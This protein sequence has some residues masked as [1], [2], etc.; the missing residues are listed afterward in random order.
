MPIPP[1]STKGATTLDQPRRFFTTLQAD[2]GLAFRHLLSFT[3]HLL[4]PLRLLHLSGLVHQIYFVQL[5]ILPETFEHWKA[6]GIFGT[7]LLIFKRDC[8]TNQKPTLNP[9]LVTQD[10]SITRPK[11]KLHPV[12]VHN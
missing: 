10:G 2:T 1:I 6:R 12:E 8:F 3:A 5:K 11:A 4:D 9:K 7:D